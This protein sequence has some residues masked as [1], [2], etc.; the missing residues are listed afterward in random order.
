MEGLLKYDKK[1]PMILKIAPSPSLTTWQAQFS[2][3][4]RLGGVCEANSKLTA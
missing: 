2:T 4:Y 1:L 3:A